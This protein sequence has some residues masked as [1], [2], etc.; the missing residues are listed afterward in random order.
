MVTSQPAE[1][2]RHL[3]LR[4]RGRTGLTQRQ[5]AERV[6]VHRRSVQEWEIGASYPS[7][8]RLQGLIRVLLEAGGLRPGHEAAEAHGLW[9]AA[10]DEARGC[11]RCSTRPGS[12]SSM[13]ASA[14]LPAP[15]TDRRPGRR[16]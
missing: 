4:Y 10:L 3:L 11:T 15:G 7:A 2:F 14:V 9:A 16:G 1:A 5:L 12:P 13:Q 8:E 6:G